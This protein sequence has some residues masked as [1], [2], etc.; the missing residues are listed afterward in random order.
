MCVCIQVVSFSCTLS[1]V[2]RNCLIHHNSTKHQNEDQ[3][4]ITTDLSARQLDKRCVNRRRREERA[5]LF[6]PSRLTV[7]PGRLQSPSLTSVAKHQHPTDALKKPR[8]PKF[9][10]YG[11]YGAF[12]DNASDDDDVSEELLSSF[13][14]LG[15]IANYPTDAPTKSPDSFSSLSPVTKYPTDAPMKS[16][17]PPPPL[18]Q[19]NNTSK[20]KPMLSQSVVGI[21]REGYD[22]HITSQPYPEGR[23]IWDLASKTGLNYEQIRAWFKKERERREKLKELYCAGFKSHQHSTQEELV[24]REALTTGSSTQQ[25]DKQ[26]AGRPVHLGE[27]NRQEATKYP[28]DEPH[29]PS[30]PLSPVNNSNASTSAPPIK[31][32]LPTMKYKKCTN[33]HPN[34]YQS[35]RPSKSLLASASVKLH[36]PTIKYKYTK[37]D[38]AATRDPSKSDK[39]G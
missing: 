11:Q 10:K 39:P 17:N 22:E 19:V 33:T 7:A 36:R 34:N 21:L 6:T 3:A 4:W 37:K 32:G 12:D 8:R 9:I 35:N 25:T 1:H 24:D 15:S 31:Q 5:E 14:S 2:K 18:I 23:E 30:P 28:T 20:T 16:R 29:K 27:T 13:S 26:N 38:Q